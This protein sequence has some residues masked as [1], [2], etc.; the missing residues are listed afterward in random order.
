MDATLLTIGAL[1]IFLGF[2]IAVS[3]ILLTILRQPKGRR[4]IKGGGVIFI[5]PIPIIFGTDKKMIGIAL[6]S[7]LII[8]LIAVFFYFTP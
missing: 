7:A 1:L 6:V 2:V 8:L 5:G 4:E 3:A